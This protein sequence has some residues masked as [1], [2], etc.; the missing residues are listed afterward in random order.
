MNQKWLLASSIIIGAVAILGV[1]IFRSQNREFVF[2]TNPLQLI[3]AKP[4]EKYSF[5]ILRQRGYPG[6]EI[7]LGDVIAEEE[8]YTAYFFSFK[9]DGKRV[10]G[11]ANIPNGLTRPGPVIVMLRGYA[12]E[13]VYFTGLGTRKAAEF[14]A[15]NG[16]ITLAPD[17]L[18]FGGSDE[19]SEDI[20]ERRFERPVTVMNLLAS[21]DS[22]DQVD[23]EK[24]GIWSHSN[25]GQIALSVLEISSKS[26]PTSLWAPVSKPFPESVTYFFG[27][28]DDLGQQVKRAIDEFLLVYDPWEFS[29]A[30][31]LAD[32]S[33]PLQVH[34]G[35][36]DP[37]IP[38]EWS[39]QF[40]GEMESLGKEID[41]F[42]YPGAD[43]NLV[44]GWDEAVARDLE[45]FRR[46]LAD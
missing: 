21:I 8:T 30:S 44:G 35:L 7:I 3:K 36:S 13:E 40:V 11:Q 33:A 39:E 43:H 25:G 5:K 32:I 6:S 15:E 12:D 28:L 4:L 1:F 9:S 27:E 45:F 22:L 29:V 10:T 17:F 14:F 18:G 34:Q 2:P 38:V 41:Y 26:Y 20:L 42:I 16:F 31:F 19:P 46:H 23:P 37:L 24:V